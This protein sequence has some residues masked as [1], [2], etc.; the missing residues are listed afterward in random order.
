MSHNILAIRY[1]IHMAQT[2]SWSDTKYAMNYFGLISA[3]YY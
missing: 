2:A 3:Q 1:T